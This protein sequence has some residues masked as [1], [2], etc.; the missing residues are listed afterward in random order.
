MRFVFLSDCLGIR[1]DDSPC[2]TSCQLINVFRTF[3]FLNNEPSAVP[4]FYLFKRPASW[5]LIKM[6]NGQIS[7]CRGPGLPPVSQAFGHVESSR[8]VPRGAHSSPITFQQ[9]HNHRTA[10]WQTWRFGQISRLHDMFVYSICPDLD[11]YR[12]PKNET[13]AL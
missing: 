4:A 2:V 13:L 10:V 5:V 3:S 8:L 12:A 6:G 7:Q 1:L 9:K 11:G